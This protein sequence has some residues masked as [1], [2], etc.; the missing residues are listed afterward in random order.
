M[1]KAHLDLAARELAGR[2]GRPLVRI[3]L[4]AV[5]SKYIGETEKNLNRLFASAQVS[6][7]VLLFDEADSLFGKRTDVK[8]AHDRYADLHS[9]DL[10]AL[11]EEHPV[12]AIMTRN[13]TSPA[14]RSGHRTK[15]LVVRFPPV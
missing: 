11:L 12:L 3:D 7:A 4:Q 13:S 8:D 1:P 10:L 15:H 14:L 6:G 2:L 5:V 9:S